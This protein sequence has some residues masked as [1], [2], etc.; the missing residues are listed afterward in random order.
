MANPLFQLDQL[1]TL[2]A[3]VEAG[4]LSAGAPRVF[5]SASAVSE[6]LRKLE[7]QAGHPLLL[8]SKGG[9]QPTPAGQRLLVWARQ[10]L[11]LNDEAYRDLRGVPLTGALRLGVTD[12]FRPAELSHLLARVQARYPGVNL[13]VS[14]LKSGLI[15]AAY[16]AGELDVGVTLRVA[17]PGSARTG[18]LLRREPLQWLAAPGWRPEPGQA[19]RLLA[20]PDSCSLHQFTVG[21]LQRRR[22][23]YVVALQASGV[24]GLQSALAA[25]LGL[26]CLN[27][28]SQ[29]PGVQAVAAPHGLPALPQAGFWVLP[30]RQGESDFVRQ[31]RALLLADLA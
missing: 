20:L 27:A 15:E 26:A 29:A 2:V 9:V 7:Q 23:P 5:L 18:Q 1:R 31:A 19:L 10:M 3:V 17:G 24:A 11:A 12:Y 16:A 14:V 28:S 6:Q 13:Q 30:A 25:G 8:R 4:S 22:V 21:L